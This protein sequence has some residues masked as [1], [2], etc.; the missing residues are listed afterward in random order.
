MS[1]ISTISTI[2]ICQLNLR[3][4]LQ[5]LVSLFLYREDINNICGANR[6]L[7]ELFIEDWQYV[8]RICLHHQPHNYD[9]N[10][11]IFMDGIQRWYKEGRYHREGDQPAIIWANGIQ[12]WYKEGK[13]HRDG[14]QPAIIFVNGTQRWYKEGN[15]HRDGDKP[16]IIFANGN[17]EWWKEGKRH[18]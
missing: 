13:M 14:D 8:Y 4:I 3:S 7:N 5:S 10:A 2:S 1:T 18:K 12:Y 9:G 16:A 15:L 6:Y 11:I 17:Q